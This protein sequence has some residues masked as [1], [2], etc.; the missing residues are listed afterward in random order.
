[1]VVLALVDVPVLGLVV[2]PAMAVVSVMA[3]VA[4]PLMKH[5]LTRG[6]G[7]SVHRLCS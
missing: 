5:G 2:V 6:F 7:L 1:V 3:L 4:V